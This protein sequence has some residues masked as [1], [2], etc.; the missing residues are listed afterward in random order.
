MPETSAI[1][2]SVRDGD[3]ASMV[4]FWAF[5]ELSMGEAQKGGADDGVTWCGRLTER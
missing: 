4:G 2:P 5:K 1:D 3:T